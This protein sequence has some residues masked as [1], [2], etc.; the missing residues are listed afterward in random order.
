MERMIS[1]FSRLQNLLQTKNTFEVFSKEEE[2]NFK[3]KFYYKTKKETFVLCSVQIHSN[4]YKKHIILDINPLDNPKFHSHFEPIF[5]QQLIDLFT[6]QER[7]NVSS[8]YFEFERSNHYTTNFM[9]S[10]LE[11]IGYT[12]SHTYRVPQFDSI[13]YGIFASG[14]H[15]D[16][17]YTFFFQKQIQSILIQE[18][19]HIISS[20]NTS[21][22]T[23]QTKYKM[24]V[25]DF[26]SLQLPGPICFYLAGETHSLSLHVH[27]DHWIVSL[28]GKQEILQEVTDTYIQDTISSMIEKEYKTLRLQN[29]FQ[30]EPY[31][32]KKLVSSEC[33]INHIHFVLL[34]SKL[35]TLYPVT[36]LEDYAFSSLQKKEKLPFFTKDNIIVGKLIDTFFMIEITEAQ[37]YFA[38]GKSKEECVERFSKEKY[39]KFEMYFDDCLSQ[40]G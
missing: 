7:L 31:F 6:N 20:I 12:K 37:C 22:Q 9:L 18:E 26:F 27:N 35:S 25:F 17:D 21:L 24:D 15:Y 40:K 13:R 19:E 39:K 8:I 32:F 10:L 14:F 3:Y 30:K 1:M 16:W 4:L 28:N 29:I 23:L 36:K 33:N 34:F 11:E 2:P 38:H 5:K